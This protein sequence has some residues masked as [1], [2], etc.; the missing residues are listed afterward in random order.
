MVSLYVADIRTETAIV[1]A[2]QRV[3]LVAEQLG[4]NVHDQ[5]RLAT[6]ASEIMRNAFQYAKGGKIEFLFN[7][8]AE[9]RL[10]LLQITD[11]GP[12]ISNVD[13][14][15][16]GRYTS[17]TGMGMGILGAK[18]LMDYFEVDSVTNKGTKVTL[19]KLIPSKSASDF[20][21]VL[22]DIQQM[23]LEQNSEISFQ[24][25]WDNNQELLRALNDLQ[26]QQDEL[27][28]L[29]RKLNDTNQGIL[30][31]YT[32]LEEKMAELQQVSD[33]KTRFISN[34]T[35]ELRTPLNTIR[36]LSDMLLNDKGPALGGEQ[37]KQVTYIRSAILD[38]IEL[39][40]DLLDNAKIEAGKVTVYPSEIN[41]QNFLK[42]LW[43]MMNP[44]LNNPEVTFIV[45]EPAAIAVLYSDEGKLAQILRNLIS[46]AFKYTEQGEVK[47]SIKLDEQRVMFLVSDTGIGIA[48]QDQKGIFE[49]FFQVRNPLQKKSKGTGLG[50]PLSRNLAQLLQGTLTLESQLGYGSIF[51]LN[52]P[53][54]FAAPIPAI[55]NI[56][57]IDD[58]ELDRHILI[59]F[60]KGYTIVE[61]ANAEDGLEK[62]EEVSPNVIFLDLDMPQITGFDFFR[63]IRHKNIPVIMYTSRK[64]TNQEKDTLLALGVVAILSK[65]Q[66]TQLQI[67]QALNQIAIA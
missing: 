52:L 64:L 55:K 36:G 43:E 60:L 15:L 11:E 53:T 67:Q 1:A 22:R 39:T 44:L 57:I 2:R 10:F 3:K 31:L 13:T 12:G 41:L 27:S 49:E 29:N 23:M 37:L 47:L 28:Q 56:L 66:T 59:G 6:A 9:N 26:K 34:I 35:H 63:T 46:N 40:N 65:L 42:T 8:Q 18:R 14:I 30:A 20:S 4:F 17:S 19:G 25:V 50:L 61:A 58:S 21:K 24:E 5:T 32:Q 51:T 62:I 33:L 7:Q 38:L 54:I 16:S 45:E 48:S